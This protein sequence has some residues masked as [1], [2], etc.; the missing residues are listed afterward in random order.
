ALDPPFAEREA[1]ATREEDGEE[2]C[3]QPASS[4]LLGRKIPEILFGIE[5]PRRS[6]HE[7]DRR[8]PLRAPT[9]VREDRSPPCRDGGV[10]LQAGAELAIEGPAEGDR[11][12]VGD[13]PLH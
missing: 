2:S 9:V 12:G 7:Q 13:R 6:S 8:C 4:P 1:T 3:N 5:L 11:H 10:D